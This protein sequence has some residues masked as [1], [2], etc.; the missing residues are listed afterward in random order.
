MNRH[1]APLDFEVKVARVIVITRNK[2]AKFLR[3]NRAAIVSGSASIV[4]FTHVSTPWT[5][6]SN[7]CEFYT[8]VE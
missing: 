8:K 5:F 1:D 7:K 2:R 3:K 6:F 4:C